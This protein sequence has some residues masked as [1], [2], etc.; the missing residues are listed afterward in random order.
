MLLLLFG[1][2]LYYSIFPENFQKLKCG[3]EPGEQDA[4]E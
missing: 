4:V 1:L 2:H 3:L